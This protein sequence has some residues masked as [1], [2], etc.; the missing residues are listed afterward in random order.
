MATNLAGY[1]AR[2]RPRVRDVVGIDIGASGVKA[3]RLRA[4][5]QGHLT[6]LAAGLLPRIDLS[7][8]DGSLAPMVLPK[9]LQGWSAAVACSFP[10]AG[11]KLLSLPADKIEG[12]AFADLLGVP[13]PPETRIGHLVFE[14]ESRSEVPVLAAGVTAS[15]VESL[16]NLFPSG[17]PSLGS[18]EVSGE[19][20]VLR[21]LAVQVDPGQPRCD[22]VIDAGERMTSMTLCH[23][24]RPLV[25]RQFP[26]GSV[27]V[28]EQVMK[29]LGVDAATA[30]DILNIGSIDVRT[31]LQRAYEVFLRQLGI[32]IDFAE[33]RSG[34]RLRRILLS[35]G[36][37]AN[38]DLC[39]ELQAQVGLQPEV[40][41]PWSGMDLA[42][43]AIP[44][45]VKGHE[46]PFAAA[47]GAAL[48]LL[49]V[50]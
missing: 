22:L 24:G 18:V 44:D 31:S 21:R 41:K 43:N 26:Q 8:T 11:V 20:V 28:V 19:R 50:A 33:R 29:D 15:S 16:L 42:P 5:R 46:A 10:Q 1:F 30:L 3:V 2:L 4:D 48:N 47:T 38:S 14:S 25:F 9:P 12:A 17:K 45:G 40:L 6:V 32:A 7:A 36:L 37:A 34:Q 27:A 35:G 23:K 13:R 39:A 49:E